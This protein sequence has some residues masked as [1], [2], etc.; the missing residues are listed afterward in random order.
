MYKENGASSVLLIITLYCSIQMWTHNSQCFHCIVYSVS[1]QE[2]CKVLIKDVGINISVYFLMETYGELIR[3][4]CT[5][6][7]CS[8][9]EEI[10]KQ[11][12]T[13]THKHYWRCIQCKCMF[14][15]HVRYCA[16]CFL[17][18]GMKHW[19]QVVRHKN[20]CTFRNSWL[21]VNASEHSVVGGR[22]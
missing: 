7:Q 12:I 19:D 14:S 21:E 9:R 13:V 2:K 10:G 17:P 3:S 15:L 11:V 22:K 1:F 18:R 6:A 16:Q 5:S 20:P 8:R 4:E